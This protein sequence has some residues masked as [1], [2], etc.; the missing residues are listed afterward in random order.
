MVVVGV[1][2]LQIKRSTSCLDIWVTIKQIHKP[3]FFRT[4][5]PTVQL[6]LYEL[7]EWVCM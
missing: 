5:K 2:D 4:Q 3:D 1:F 6:L 7:L